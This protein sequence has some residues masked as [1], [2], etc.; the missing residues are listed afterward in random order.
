MMIQNKRNV[1]LQIFTH[2]FGFGLS[3]PAGESN[4]LGRTVPRP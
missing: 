3:N 1:F 4:T 2:F